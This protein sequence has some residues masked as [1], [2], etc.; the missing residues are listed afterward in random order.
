MTRYTFERRNQWRGYCRWAF[1]VGLVLVMALA[2]MPPQ[3][4]MPTTGWDKANHALAFAV[5]A[6]LGCAAYPRRM[7]V[8]LIG[9][10]AYGGLIE[11]LQGLTPH[12][13][14]EW[15]DVGADGVGLVVGSMLTRVAPRRVRQD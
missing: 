15:L 13:T 5:L 9:L 6:V 14:S 8:V 3:V 11:L 2:L 7:A 4:P 10:L 1:A 12:R